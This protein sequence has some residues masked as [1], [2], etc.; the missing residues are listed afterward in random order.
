MSI[1]STFSH[2]FTRKGGDAQP[3]EP[4]RSVSKETSGLISTFADEAGRLSIELTDVGGHVEDV[5]QHIKTQAKN[6]ENLLASSEEMLHETARIKSAVQHSRDVTETA[7]SD[8]A[9]SRQAIDSTLT[10]VRSMTEAV[11]SIQDQLGSVKNALDRVVKVVRD[12]A[13]IANQSQMLAINATIEA[14]KA[15]RAGRGFAVV[16]TEVKSLAEKTREAT[17]GIESTIG[18]LSKETGELI[19]VSANSTAKANFVLDS[20]AKVGRLIETAGQ[21]NDQVAEEFKQINQASHEIEER[22]AHFTGI[23]QDLAEGVVQSSDNL[24]SARNRVNQVI[25]TSEH[26]VYLTAKSGADTF[27]KPFVEMALKTAAAISQVLE[28]ALAQGRIKE[29]DLFDEEY[30]P[31]PNTDPQQYMSRFTRFTDQVLPPVQ[32]PVLDWNDKVAFCAAIDRKCYLPTHN[33]KYSQPQG[34][35]PAWNAANCRNRRFFDDRVGLSAVNNKREFLLQTYRRDMGGGQ[36]V[37]MKD[38]SAPVFVHGRHWGC[39]RIGF[40]NE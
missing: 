31:I 13:K 39:L 29:N 6:F 8:V 24:E 36:F 14:A 32:E 7:R 5:S 20:T 15:G 3:D 23:V 33:K 10:D 17:E 35:D 30:T 38:A 12:I 11:T 22:C 26:L 34:S 9:A 16:A 28:Q 4:L 21:A 1:L 19:A 18:E 40:K 27:D 37:L 2:Y 25:K